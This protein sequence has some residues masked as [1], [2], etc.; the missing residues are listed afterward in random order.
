MSDLDDFFD[1]GND[2]ELRVL[3]HQGFGLG[4]TLD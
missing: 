1:G 4:A 2:E 3:S